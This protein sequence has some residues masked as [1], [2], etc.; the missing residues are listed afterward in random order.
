MYCRTSAQTQ[1]PPLTLIFHLS[2]TCSVELLDLLLGT[3]FVYI[4]C[5]VRV[6]DFAQ[7]SRAGSQGELDCASYLRRA[8][9]MFLQFASIFKCISVVVLAREVDTELI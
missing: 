9:Y 7:Q 2:N 8:E 6:S 5:I 1:I 3:L 4:Q